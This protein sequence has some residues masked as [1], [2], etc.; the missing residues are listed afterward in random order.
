[1]HQFDYLTHK[2]E[3][4]DVVLALVLDAA[5]EVDGEHA[6]GAGGHAART[7]GVAETVVLDLVSQTAAA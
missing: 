2:L 6:L 1:M 5:V 7:E 4:R 3:V